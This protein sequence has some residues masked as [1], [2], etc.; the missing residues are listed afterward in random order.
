MYVCIYTYV[1]TY[2]C[3]IIHIY[4]G[5]PLRRGEKGRDREALVSRIISAYLAEILKSQRL[6]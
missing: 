6:A 4:T 1:Y 2:I 3:I 5:V